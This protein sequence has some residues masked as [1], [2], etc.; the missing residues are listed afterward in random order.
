MVEDRTNP[1]RPARPAKP[2]NYPTLKQLSL[3][4]T[5]HPALQA[6]LVVPRIP[7]LLQLLHNPQIHKQV[8]KVQLHPL[9]IITIKTAQVRQLNQIESLDL[10]Q[11]MV[12]ASKKGILVI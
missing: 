7:S 2:V 5:S 12:T 11:T 8:D 4:A 1:R 10:P 3:L 6:N 9:P